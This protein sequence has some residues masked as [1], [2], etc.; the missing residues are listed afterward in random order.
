MKKVPREKK[1]ATL[2]FSITAL[3]VLVAFIALMLTVANAPVVVVM[4]FAWVVLVPFALYLGYGLDDIEKSGYELIKAAV[5]LLALMVAIGAMI[6]IWLCAGTVPTLIYWGLE[7]LSPK[8]F[9]VVAFIVTSVVSLPTGTSW[10]TVS[11]VGVAMMGVGL[12]LG[13]PPGVVAGAIISGAYFGDKFSPISDAPIMVSSV[14]GMPLWDHIRHM[15]VTTSIAWVLSA[16]AYMI[17]GARFANTAL[18]VASINDLLTS[19]D[20]LF[21]I[22]IITII[23]MALVLVLLILQVSAFWSIL[24]GSIVGAL[25]SIFYQG[26]TLAE[27]TAFMNTGFSIQSDNAILSSLLNRG[28]MTSMY[29]LVAVIIGSLGLGGILKGTG[30]LDVLITSMSKSLKNVRSLTIVTTIACFIT[31]AMVG[32]YYFC[33][34]FVGTLMTPLY[35]KAGLKPENPGRIIN[36]ISNCLVAFIPWNV[37]AIYMSTQLG[38][39]IKDFIPYIFFSIF[40]IVLDV[41]FGV[42]GINVKRYT[43]EEMAAFEKE[44]AAEITAAN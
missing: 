13:L 24:A 5:G 12:G 4:L 7:L 17:L 40:L 21:N 26:F 8:M 41:L 1:K 11:T 36:D 38:V 32:T 16:I 35:K 28:G 3:L 2:S 42:L 43:P 39:P 34:T 10:G 22:G 19:L 31:T 29:E 9:L 14:C 20:S 27:V 18:D 6:S 25:V 37:G 15:S 23:P 33:Q 44:E 30:M